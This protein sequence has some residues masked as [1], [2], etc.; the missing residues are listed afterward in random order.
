MTTTIF[1]KESIMALERIGIRFVGIYLPSNA[2]GLPW[3]KAYSDPEYRWSTTNL[4]IR[5]DR[6]TFS[7]GATMLGPTH[8]KDQESGEC[9][10]L[11]A[12]DTDCQ[13]VHNRLSVSIEQLLDG[14]SWDW[15]TPKLQELVKAFLHSAGVVNGD[16][17]Q[18]LLDVL[19]KSTFVT[20]TRQVYGHH[21]YWLERKQRKAIK[22]ADCR[23]GHEFEI[24]TDN[25][26][27]LCTLPGS[28]H[29]E[30]L[31][32]RYSTVGITDRLLVN[33]ILYDLLV[34]MFKDCLVN[35]K[36]DGDDTTKEDKK[37]SH[38]SNKGEN[39]KKQKNKDRV[40]KNLVV[41]S[42]SI[43][44]ATAGYLSEF[45]AKGYRNSFYICFSGMLFHSR[46]SEGSAAQI[47]GALCAISA[48]EESRSRQSTLTATY[49]KGFNGEEIEGAPKLA[50]LIADKTAGQDVFSATLLLDNL[51]Y[52]WRT[53]RKVIQQKEE[54]KLVPEICIRGKEDAIWLCPS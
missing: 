16:Y 15:V 10:N 19:K 29:R 9:L 38:N 7:N 53:D 50:E 4:A 31:N 49:E 41:L 27:G 54:A 14:S 42:P 17:S 1:T 28:A 34:E 52:I 37:K 25:S 32:F 46:I 3:R 2:T 23:K 30:D 36:V 21:I 11:N 51:K 39:E 47:I 20:K 22:T 26:S 45:V 35:G 5:Q 6:Y 8:I 24:K 40:I 44:K 18:S 12:L 33:D 43:I 13:V 48:D